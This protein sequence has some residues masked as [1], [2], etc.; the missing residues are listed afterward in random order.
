MKK[1]LSEIVFI[2]DRSGSM[3]GLESDTIGGYN[4]FI[5]AQRKVKGEAQVTTILFDDKY[6]V[7]HDGVDLKNVNPITEKEYFARGTTALLDAIGKTMI[8][9]GRRL[10]N[11]AENER[12]SKV[13]VVITTD[14]HEN[15]SREFSYKKINEFITNQQFKYSWE[16]IFL[17]AN[18]DAAKEA[19]NLGIKPSRAANYVAD[20][21]GTNVMYST[22]AQNIASYRETGNLGDN[23]SNDINRNTNE[24]K[25]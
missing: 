6:D 25:K 4:S 15:S 23:L 20:T 3:A 5:T 14:G 18:I 16:F 22:L 2:L 21:K 17:G 7:L 11:T 24:I 9:V 12:P 10:N 8:D 1:D 13:I 19:K